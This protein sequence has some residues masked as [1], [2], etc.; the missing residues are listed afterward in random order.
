MLLMKTDPEAKEKLQFEKKFY[1]LMLELNLMNKFNLTYWLDVTEKTSYGFNAKLHLDNGLSFSKI[2]ENIGVIQENLKC[3]WIMEVEQFKDY[4]DVKIVTKPLDPNTAFL[5]P[6]I[7][8]W[9]LYMGLDFL[10]KPIVNDNND[11]CMFLLAGAT[12]SG[13]TRF[14]YMVLLAWILGCQVNEVE[15]Y[16]GDIAKNEYV[17]FQYVKHVRYYA[18]ELDELLKMLQYI[19]KKMQKRKNLITKFREQGKATNIVEFNKIVNGKMSY[20]YVFIDEFSVIIPD[21]S[22]CEDEK[23]M[24]QQ[25]LDILKRI[26]KIGRS[27]GV[28]VFLATQKTTKDEIPAII[29]NMSAV[30]I[31]FRANDLISS[32]VIIGSNA[33]VGLAN[34]YAIYSQNGGEKK[35]YLFSPKL[36]TE[37]L[38][39]LLKPFERKERKKPELEFDTEVENTSVRL[40]KRKK[41]SNTPNNKKDV[42]TVQNKPPVKLLL[43]GDNYIDY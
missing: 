11:Y 28:F 30:R 18:S 21:K 5:N 40:D 17:K 25:C 3:L 39:T 23:K 29:K 37:D 33:A 26:S 36:E 6:H 10:L 4:A 41:A 20:T 38:N 22:D 2:T 24:K 19:E 13:K 42:I 34:R 16:I 43:K 8:P 1:R 9:Q 31:S 35:N 7:R 27:L 32:E 14:M 12:G 15:L